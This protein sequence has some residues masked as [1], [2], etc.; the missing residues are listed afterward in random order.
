MNFARRTR[1]RLLF[2]SLTPILVLVFA[3]A[4]GFPQSSISD[5]S[6]KSP[7]HLDSPEFTDLSRRAQAALDADQ[8]DKAIPLLRKALV[9]KPRWTEGWWL[10][11]TS[12]YDQSRYAEAG[13]AFQKVVALDP[14]HGTAHALLGLCQFEL[15]DDKDALQNIELSKNLG[16]SVDPQLR[17]VVFYHEGILLQRAGRFIGAQ[18]AFS[19]LCLGGTRSE[20]VVR[21]FGMAALRMADRTSP[22]QDT[23]RGR[24]VELI[25]RAAC[26]AAQKDFDSARRL[27]TA[28]ATNFPDFP[29]VHYAYGRELVD[30][31]DIAGAVAQFKSELA[32]GH[33][34]VLAMLQIAAAEYKIDSPAGLPYAEQAVK[35]APQL[36]FAHFL[37]GLLLMNTGAYSAAL[38]QLEIAS[39]GLPRDP[40]VWWALGAAYEQAGR[41][42]DASKARA[43][44]IALKQQTAQQ[45]QSA[46]VQEVPVNVSFG[47]DASPKN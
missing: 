1:D 21:G 15:G 8:L 14:K 32:L 45:P 10:L 25:G 24:V 17:D 12:Y 28:A 20:D 39:R 41:L 38:P 13:L 34:R 46:D 29:Y 42:Q 4:C 18:A 43:Q 23:E 47:T 30:E 37:Y 40:K 9:L 19:S 16:T 35:A 3:P 7:R 27:Y 5:A 6:P 31:H 36:P 11:G 33:D 26:L 44:F 22:S 2:F